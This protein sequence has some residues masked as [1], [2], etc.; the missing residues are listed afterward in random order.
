M[1]LKEVAVDGA[2]VEVQAPASGSASINASSIASI[3]CKAE[4]K[5]IY[6]SRSNAF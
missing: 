1:S 3:K 6:S 5:G 2:T 4:S